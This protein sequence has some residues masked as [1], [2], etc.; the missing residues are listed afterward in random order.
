MA[1]RAEK[2]VPWATPLLM[3]DNIPVMILMKAMK[4]VVL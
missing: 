2:A 3:H 1:T 4:T